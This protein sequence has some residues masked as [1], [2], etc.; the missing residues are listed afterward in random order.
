MR[1]PA[2]RRRW[3]CYAHA[4]WA[5]R[6]VR[7]SHPVAFTGAIDAAGNTDP[8][9]DVENK[10]AAA[11]RTGL[12]WVVSPREG[13]PRAGAGQHILWIR[14]GV[15]ARDA[16]A[17][18]EELLRVDTAS[19]WWS[20]PIAGTPWLE[21]AESLLAQRDIEGYT[22]FVKRLQSAAEP[23]ERPAAPWEKLGPV[24]PGDSRG[25]QRPAPGRST[26]GPAA[27]SIRP[28][29]F[30]RTKRCAR[31]SSSAAVSSGRCFSA[32][33]ISAPRNCPERRHRSR[34]GCKTRSMTRTST[35]T[36]G[37]MR[38]GHGR[39]GSSI[40]ESWPQA[41][42]RP[43]RTSWQPSGYSGARPHSSTRW[44]I[45]AP[46]RDRGYYGLGDSSP[47][48]THIGDAT[49]TPQTVL[50]PV[51]QTSASD[52]GASAV[53]TT[54][55]ESSLSFQANWRFQ[56]AY[57]VR[58]FALHAATGTRLTA[59]RQAWLRTAVPH[60][61]AVG[62]AGEY[63][64]LA[65][66]ERSLLGLAR[67]NDVPA[68]QLEDAWLTLVRAAQ[69]CPE[70]QVIAWGYAA[71]TGGLLRQQDERNASEVWLA[72]RGTNARTYPGVVR[73]C[74]GVAKRGRPA[75]SRCV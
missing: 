61:R 25:Y 27:D 50:E 5:K 22:A 63:H 13:E 12:A 70:H 49:N 34:R 74:R 23:L 68:P 8:V 18:A 55:N 1:W 17:E 72:A 38:A 15:P 10:A 4:A 67:D 48:S 42:T 28:C 51:L 60:L 59:A 43:N 65:I 40:S 6:G 20:T 19:C 62:K 2:A 73:A 46:T 26:D 47:S 37:S 11:R 54:S 14:A 66:L 36:R 64:L 9:T 16:L 57:A 39:S 33:S 53:T 41:R 44:R 29:D 3:P 7:P 45:R 35:M 52:A 31:A 71:V 30:A 32:R 69:A 21:L 75:A 58:L 24:S 56:A